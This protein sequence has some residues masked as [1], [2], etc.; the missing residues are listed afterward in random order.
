[1]K[2]VHEIEIKIDGKKWEDYLDASFKKKSK[3]VEIDGF[4]KGAIPK[5][6]Y[7]KKFGIESLFM[8]AV[9][10]AMSEAYKNALQEKK[11]IP[12]TEPNVDIKTITDKEVVF[13]FTIITKPE[14]E[15]GEYKNLGIKQDEVKVTEEEITEEINQ[16]QTK[17]AEIVV[18]EEGTVEEGNTAVIDF[19]GKVDG[20]VFEG[21]T[22]KDYPL[23]IGSK[24]FIPGF[25]EAVVG[26]KVGETKDI[27]L[28]FPENYV[29]DLANKDVVFTT[30]VTQIK[31]RV[32]PKLNKDF[33]EDLGYEN[34]KNEDELKTKIKEDIKHRKQH[35]VENKFV[36]EIL[37]QGSKKMKVEIN[38][39]IIHG[40]IHRM[41]HQYEEQLKT[42]GLNLEQYF[43][44]TNTTREDLEKMMEEEA[45]KRVKY[46]YFLEAVAEKEKIEIEDKEV[47]EESTKLAKHYGMEKEEFI[48]AFGGT[49]MIKY[50]LKM[51]KAMELIKENN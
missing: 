49:D 51:R 10:P 42:Q 2:N 22:G 44:F 48:N 17:L 14:V 13:K 37:E 32:L 11:I 30:T 5:D 47:E 28:K 26:M 39:E 3:D 35:D 6:V 31:E 20:E 33:Y 25:E 23:E 36:E 15:L 24:T 45:S 27:N 34:V 19:E 4:R 21:G 41:V 16:L 9:D 40:E 29:Q 46:R 8:D 50:D 1:M 18:K 12:E 7:I 43:E 38:E